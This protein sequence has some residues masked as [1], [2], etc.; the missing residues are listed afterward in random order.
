[1]KEIT[2]KIEERKSE[3]I[4][5]NGMLKTYG[6]MEQKINDYLGAKEECEI[7][8]NLSKEIEFLEYYNRLVLD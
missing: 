6:Y 7:I 2:K 3:I 4:K 8:V 1:M 5:R